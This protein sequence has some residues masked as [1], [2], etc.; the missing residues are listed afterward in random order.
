MSDVDIN[1]KIEFVYIYYFVDNVEKY[2]NLIASHGMDPEEILVYA[3]KSSRYTVYMF[4]KTFYEENYESKLVDDFYSLTH[5]GPPNN[6]FSI[7]PGDSNRVKMFKYSIKEMADLLDIEDPRLLSYAAYIGLKYL[8]K[9]NVRHLVRT[10]LRGLALACFKIAYEH[11]D[12][13][14]PDWDDRIRFLAEARIIDLREYRV[15]LRDLRLLYGDGDG[16][17]I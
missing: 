17:G 5:N 16:G 1:L 15:F 2:L 8:R 11:K 3:D 14:P 12:I 10:K 13:I 9:K 7:K 4:L 6:F